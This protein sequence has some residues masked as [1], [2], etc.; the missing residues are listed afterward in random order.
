MSSSPADADS[1]ASPS[2]DTDPPDDKDVA[3]HVHVHLAVTGAFPLRV[4]DLLFTDE[5]VV[6]PEY[7]HLTPLFGIARSGVDTAGERA[8]DRYRDAGIAGLVDP[9]ERVHRLPHDEVAA[10]RL[11]HSRVGRPKLAVVA[12]SGPPYAY[13]IHAPVDV[14]SLASALESLGDRRGFDVERRAK[15]GYS[16]VASL[17]RFVAGR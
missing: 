10:V 13:R 12:D 15:I 11:Y 3:V 17:R 9:A 6:I 4:A 5:A 7:E 1:D 2:D 14:D 16:P 8:R